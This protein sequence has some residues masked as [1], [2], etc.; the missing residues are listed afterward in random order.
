MSE[1]VAAKTNEMVRTIQNPRIQM[2]AAGATVGI[3]STAL[4]EKALWT[5]KRDL[6]GWETQNG[7]FVG[8][9]ASGKPLTKVDTEM[10][11]SYNI[12]RQLA[13]VGL[14][15]VLLGGLALVKGETPGAEG[16]RMGLITGAGI[17]LAHGIQDN[18]NQLSTYQ[19]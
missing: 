3:I 12:R 18:V 6:F 13:R 8:L 4:A 2:A 10:S 15:A 1:G 7:V 11:K 16:L 5:G 9:D 14:A 19:M 17:L